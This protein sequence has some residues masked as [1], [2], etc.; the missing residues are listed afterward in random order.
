MFIVNPRLFDFED[1]ESRNE[2]QLSKMSRKMNHLWKVCTAD[3]FENNREV[4]KWNTSKTFYRH[5]SISS[6][7]LP[8]HLV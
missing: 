4:I 7:Y 8:L 2:L 6:R 3:T 1:N 5:D